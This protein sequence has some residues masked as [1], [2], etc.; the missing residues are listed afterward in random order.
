MTILK[1]TNRLYYLKMVIAYFKTEIWKDL[2][3]QLDNIL[4]SK[5]MINGNRSIHSTMIQIIIEILFKFITD[6]RI[7]A[8]IVQK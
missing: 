2:R 5:Y 8:T 7:M 4:T 3:H 6:T 1:F